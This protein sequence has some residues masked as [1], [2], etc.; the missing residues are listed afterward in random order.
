MVCEVCCLLSSS[1]VFTIRKQPVAAKSHAMLLR[2]G[3]HVANHYLVGIQQL[4]YMMILIPSL[5]FSTPRFSAIN[6]AK[7]TLVKK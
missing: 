3:A 4:K 1:L 5:A 7:A 6:G 2:L